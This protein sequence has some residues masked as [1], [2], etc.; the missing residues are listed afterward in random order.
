MTTFDMPTMLSELKRDEGVKTKP[1]RDTVGKL[2][3]GVGRNLDDVGVSAEEIS[4]M[5]TND[6][7]RTEVAL[8]LSLPWWR[9]LDPV[10]QRVI[11]NMAF[12]M[13]VAGLLTFNNTLAAVKRGDY[14]AAA[15]GMAAS[16]W[17]TQVHD[18]A[19]RLIKMMQ[20]GVTA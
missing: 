15:I 14:A 11:L 19:A 20:T 2:S 7:L 17:A 5:L 6:I 3:I 18:R 16:K 12:N 9:T 1:Y 10:R 13:G 8:D 4:L